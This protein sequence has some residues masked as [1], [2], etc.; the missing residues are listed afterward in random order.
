MYCISIWI[1]HSAKDYLEKFGAFGFADD[2]SMV[3]SISDKTKIE[4]S[5]N[6][7]IGHNVEIFDSDFHELDPKNRNSGN[8][9]TKPVLIGENV[10]IGSNCKILKGVNIGRNSIIANGSIVVN[11]IPENVIAG[12]IPAKFIKKL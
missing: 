4:I 6:V 11:D 12:G 2:D 9:I 5:D 10:F 3:Q 8:H 7:L 1:I